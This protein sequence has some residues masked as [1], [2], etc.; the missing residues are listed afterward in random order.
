MDKTVLV[1]SE[2][3]DVTLIKKDL[4]AGNVV[5]GSSDTILG[6]FADT[7]EAGVK[8]LNSIKSRDKKPYLIL[9]ARREDASFF[10]SEISG[11]ADR[12]MR[13]CWPGPLTLILKA[14]KGLPSYLVGADG[15]VALRVPQHTPLLGLLASFK[16]LF[17]TSA[18][19]AG[20]AVPSCVEDLN[21][22]ILEGVSHLVVDRIAS[23][24]GPASTIIDASG[25]SLKL[26]RAGAYPLADLERV[27]ESPIIKF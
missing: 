6:L 21:S 7:T 2:P 20:D 8:R 27:A 4:L 19:L 12:L 1:W 3:A 9:I 18:N 5:A 25:P 13:S 22:S 23:P 11:P 16:G 17:S 10:V 15:T 14:R 24:S 26:I